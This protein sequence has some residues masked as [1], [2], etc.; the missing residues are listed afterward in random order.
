MYPIHTLQEA[1]SMS[2][3]FVSVF[4][5]E[6]RDRGATRY[7]QLHFRESVVV[8]PLPR[9]DSYRGNARRL[10]RVCMRHQK[11]DFGHYISLVRRNGMRR[12]QV[13]LLFTA[14]SCCSIL[15][16]GIVSRRI[17]NPTPHTNGNKLISNNKRIKTGTKSS[18]STQRLL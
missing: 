10:A 4:G 13:F 1:T 3:C 12:A 15:N 6:S 8:V 7:N 17:L 9:R 2:L 14:L 5:R 16:I 18:P 11:W